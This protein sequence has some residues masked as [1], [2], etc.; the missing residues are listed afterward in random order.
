M[1]WLRLELQQ[2][3]A[4]HR[5]REQREQRAQEMRGEVAWF[6]STADLQFGHSLGFDYPVDGDRRPIL[7][8]C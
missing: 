3:A 2:L 4:E 7:E 1:H 6:M 5:Q 8:A